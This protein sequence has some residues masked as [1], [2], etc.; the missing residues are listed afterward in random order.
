[1]ISADKA[2]LLALLVVLSGCAK[3]RG[4]EQQAAQELAHTAAQAQAKDQPAAEE[5]NRRD[6]VDSLLL[7]NGP[8]SIDVAH[9]SFLRGL[10]L[11]Q[12]GQAQYAEM[13][14]K[15]ALAN[16][17]RNRFL[18]FELAG[19]LAGEEKSGEALAIARAGERYPGTPNSSEYHLLASLYRENGLVDSAKVYYRKAIAENDQNLKAL[20]E[21][22]LLLEVLQE[23]QELSKVFDLLLPLLDYPRPMIEKQLLLYKLSQNDSAMVKLLSTAFQ[24][25][26][27]GDY[28]RML[29]EVLESQGKNA[30]AQQAVVQSLD[31]DPTDR[32]SWNAL[33]RLQLRAGQLEEARRSQ[34]RL[35]SL[36]TTQT[37]VLQ[38]L[39]ML[40][41]DVGRLDSAGN[42]F[43]RLAKLDSNDHVARF[44]LSHLAQLAGDS[45]T[46]LK[47]IREALALKPD[48][49]PYHNQLGAIYYL[50]SNYA[51]AHA[52]FDSTLAHTQH[53]L[54]MQ[55]KASAY[56]HEAQRSPYA[57]QAQELRLQAREWLLKAL[58][59]DSTS[60]DLM[61]ETAS[62]FERLDSLD[63]AQYWFNRLLTRDPQNHV[64]LNYLGYMLVDSQRDIPLGAALIDSALALS[65]GNTAYMDSR[66][67][68]LYRQQRF[69]DALKVMESVEAAG[70]DDVT[71]WEHMAL[72]CEALELQERAQDYWRRVLKLEPDHTKALKKLGEMP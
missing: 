40:E 27:D 55:L 18:A 8:P 68:A 43:T 6:A 60:I 5:K 37:D 29:A 7:L 56:V 36:D 46:A 3:T 25:H 23:Y 54:P 51:E 63:A 49:L 71:L 32:D 1:M 21:F 9:E 4:P 20:Y 50:S 65:P 2:I 45:A 35:Y 12:V 22:S 11:M 59:L 47:R 15:R 58:A 52:V 34:T 70:M 62:N 61:F 42:H 44:Y 28:A 14:Y 38:R 57:T 64:A 67:W 66:G 26:G 41:Y 31:I 30:E 17:P 39:A 10:S 16:A 72:I 24:V 48:A 13:Y 53:P 69:A 19:I 33:V